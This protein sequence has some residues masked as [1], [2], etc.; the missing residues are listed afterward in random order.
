MSPI[1][2]FATRMAMKLNSNAAFNMSEQQGSKC[3]PLLLVGP[4]KRD[5][6]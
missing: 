1:F 4:R 6:S 3:H 5:T 2:I